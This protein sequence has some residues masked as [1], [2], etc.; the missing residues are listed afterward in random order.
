MVLDHITDRSSLIVK[1]TATLY[2]EILCHRDLNALD[3]VAVPKS[4]YKSV[5]KT[6]RQHV[7][8]C[9]L[10]KVVID[11]EDVSFVEDA[12]QHAVQLLRGCEVVPEGLFHDDLGPSSAVRFSQMPDHSFEQHR[13][14]CQVMRWPFR[15]FELL[16]KHSEGRWILIVTVHIPQK[17]DE[18]FESGKIGPTMFLQAVLCARGQ[19]IEIPSSFCDSDHG[20]VEVPSF[21][22]RLQGRENLFVGEIAGGAKKNECV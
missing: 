6:E 14:D 9:S 17:A 22:H 19:L 5:G 1:T 11:A 20:N 4:L 10:A 18:L 13:R 16:A 2:A 12:Q 21:H 7:V 3:A 15:V 8:D